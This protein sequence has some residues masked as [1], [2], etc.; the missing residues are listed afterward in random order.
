MAWDLPDPKSFDSIIDV[1]DD[2]ATRWAGR[3]QMALR[4]DDG[5]HLP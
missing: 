2:A 1:I 5:L 4:T 3:E